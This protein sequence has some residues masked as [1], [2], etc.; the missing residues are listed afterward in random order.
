MKKI[1][2]DEN[3]PRRLEQDFSDEDMKAS[4]ISTE[5]WFGKKDKEVLELMVEFE[6][7]IL[8]SKNLDNFLE[9]ELKANQI[10]TNIIN[11][12]KSLIK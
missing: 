8:L 6:F 11:S 7:D 2:I 3:L 10:S 1:L 4:S 9:L 5:G 12:L